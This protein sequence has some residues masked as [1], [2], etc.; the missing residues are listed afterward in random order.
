VLALCAERLPAVAPLEN[1]SAFAPADARLRVLAAAEKYENTPY[2]FGGLDRRG[3]DCSGLIYVSFQD[4]LEISVPRSAA[5][6]Y[7]WAEKIPIENARPGDLVFFKT[8]SNEKISHVGIFVGDKRFIHSASEGPKT[9][10][11]YSSLNERYWSLTYAGAGRALPE[12]EISSGTDKKEAVEIKTQES[13][14]KRGKENTEKAKILLGVA[15]APTWGT[16]LAD[17]NIVR[18]VEGQFRFGIPVKPFG[19]PMIFGLELRQEWDS[20]LGVYRIPIT[21]SWGINDKVRIFGG[22]AFS[23]G[24][25]SLTAS[26]EDRNYIGGTYWFGEAG[27]SVAPFAINIAGNDLAPYAELAWQSYFSDHNGKNFGADFAASFRFST[28]IR[29][30]W[31][32]L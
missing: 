6:L 9:G 15:V 28:G 14:K 25:A 32:A 1:G 16:W 5:D 10:V 22:P 31:K 19:Q 21:L 29:Y 24:D 18:G 27:I 13:K 7:S 20:V 17:S 4:A 3:L 8:G 11:I 12:A 26:G 23:F 2:R 30:T